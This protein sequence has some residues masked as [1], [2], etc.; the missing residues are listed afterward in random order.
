MKIWL[1]GFLAGTWASLR[2]KMMRRELLTRLM[3]DIAVLTFEASMAE[4][5]R[6]NFQ[7]T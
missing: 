4:G 6:T 5:G 2:R 1:E 3:L 7:L